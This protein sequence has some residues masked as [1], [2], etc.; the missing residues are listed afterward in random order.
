MV[1]QLKNILLLGTQSP[2]DIMSDTPNSTS[3]WQIDRAKLWSW[4][5][6]HS[7]RIPSLVPTILDVAGK[8]PQPLYS[9]AICSLGL[10]R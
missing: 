8:A 7:M 4:Q 5:S 6:V 3:N 10:R 9:L 2:G 1:V